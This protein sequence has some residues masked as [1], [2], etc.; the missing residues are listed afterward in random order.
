[1]FRKLDSRTILVESTEQVP[2]F[3]PRPEPVRVA[4]RL[5]DHKALLRKMRWSPE[6]YEA[7][8]AYDFPIARRRAE[9][10][11]LTLIWPEDA[12]DTWIVS[13]REKADQIRSLI[14]D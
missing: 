3:P 7:A 13:M 11:T 14:G 9:G 12:I 6:Q 2:M 10:W 8:Q 4:P 1:M 5:I